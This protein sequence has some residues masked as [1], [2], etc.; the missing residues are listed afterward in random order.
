MFDFDHC[1]LISAGETVHSLGGTTNQP[2][3]SNW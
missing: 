1:P 2:E 3:T